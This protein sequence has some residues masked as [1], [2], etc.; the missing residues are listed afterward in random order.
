MKKHPGFFFTCLL[1]I[2]PVIVHAGICDDVRTIQSAS[3]DAL[4]LPQAL[5]ANNGKSE[6]G[7]SIQGLS[8]EA[9]RGLD[10]LHDKLDDN[11]PFHG[12]YVIGE[13]ARRSPDEANQGYLGLEWQIFRRGYFN[14]KQKA[15]LSTTDALIDAYT[16]RRH[17]RDQSLDQALH[18]VKR[19]QNTLLA[20][21][22][23]QMLPEQTHLTSLYRKRMK[24]GFITRQALAQEE[25]SL[26]SIQ[27]KVSLYEQLPQSPIPQDLATLINHIDLLRLQ[28]L[29]ELE[30]QALSQSGIDELQQLISRQSQLS[31]P[32]WSD[33]LT[34]G[35][36]ARRRIDYFGPAGNEMGIQFDIPLDGNSSHDKVVQLRAHLQNLQL[37]AD[38][39]RLRE[40]LASL[41]D[42][43]LHAQDLV[44]Q[45]QN[46][47]HLSLS[48]AGMD[49]TQSHHVVPTL[50]N[51]PEKSLE[52]LPVNLLDQQRNIFV[53]RLDTYRLLLQ[54]QAMVQPRPGAAWYSTR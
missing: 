51:T 30:K 20:F 4:P 14:G 50:E 10:E 38:K 46:T 49:C 44:H 41:S 24:A 2:A 5:I 47:Y 6:P 39:I 1:S 13:A 35:I 9:E 12:L 42:Q 15:A 48:Q 19:M 54:L 53:A 52:Q 7:T 31:T 23:G 3:Q 34:L 21:L 37:K 8:M 22:Y 17:L 32:R 18:Q 26:Q 40:K 29:A 16:L 43:F 36:Y 45:L 25:S 33:N 11:T 27:D 28:P